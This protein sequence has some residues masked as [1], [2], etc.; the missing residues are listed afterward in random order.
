MDQQI[1]INQKQNLK[2]KTAPIVEEIQQEQNEL[3]F[4][5]FEDQKNSTEYQDFILK[6]SKDVQEYAAKAHFDIKAKETAG[7]NPMQEFTPVNK[8]IE[9]WKARRRDEARVKEIKKQYPKNEVLDY[10]A[11]RCVERFKADNDFGTNELKNYC[12]RKKLDSKKVIS[13][14]NEIDGRMLAM[15]CKRYQMDGE[16]NPIGEKGR[17]A[18]QYNERMVG[19]WLKKDLSV[20]VPFL[21]EWVNEVLTFRL[22]IDMTDFAWLQDHAAE[23][24][25]MMGKLGYLKNAMKDKINKPFFDSLPKDVLDLIHA[26]ADLSSAMNGVLT[27][28]AGQKGISL[29]TRIEIKTDAKQ[30]DVNSPE[31]KEQMK[32]LL[33]EYKRAEKR[34]DAVSQRVGAKAIREEERKA[35]AHKPINTKDELAEYTIDRIKE[36]RAAALFRIESSNLCRRVLADITILE[37]EVGSLIQGAKKSS[38][39]S[40]LKIEIDKKLDILSQ[41]NSMEYSKKYMGANEEEQKQNDEAELA[42]YDHELE[43]LMQDGMSYEAALNAMINR[44]LKAK[45]PYT[46]KHMGEANQE[47]LEAY[48]EKEEKT[49]K[50]IQKFNEDNQTNLTEK[51]ADNLIKDYI[52]A[53]LKN[54]PEKSYQIRV[55][56]P[57]TIGLILNTGRFKT[58]IEGQVAK[59][60][61]GLDLFLRRYFTDKVFGTNKLKK[62]NQKAAEDLYEEYKKIRDNKKMDPAE[63]EKQLRVIEEKLKKN[64]NLNVLPNDQYE[65]YGYLSQGDLKKEVKSSINEV[66][67]YGQVI[68]KLKSER[69]KERITMMLGDSLNA[70]EFGHPVKEGQP[71]G[72][73]NIGIE[74][75][76]EVLKKAYEYA[77]RK[78]DP[79]Y[80][81]KNDSELTLDSILGDDTMTPYMELQFH[82]G[83]P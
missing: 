54:M 27:G 28:K 55:G 76:K 46:L 31:A 74:G 11:L 41:K 37:Q 2:I 24:N 30:K 23:F 51:E 9:G 59:G 39:I 38:A 13:D 44:H 40:S 53:V 75:R 42:A 17:E 48:K 62:K 64:E 52:D 33:D 60:G 78:K 56:D 5:S 18:R 34:L 3:V 22:S 63:K 81:P 21:Q 10:R 47:H 49:L 79:N 61:G 16:G 68:V 7:G 72:L 6:L 77:K 25:G 50:T 73:Y 71:L 70:E 4:K 26:K 80:D 32:A 1:I 45:A 83:Y 57:N 14:D 69:M 43:S 8:G 29:T 35:K 20:R 82:G 15:Y 19:A 67:T 65:V 36:L 58:Q 12:K 66:S